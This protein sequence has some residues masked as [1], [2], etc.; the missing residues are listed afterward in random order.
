MLLNVSQD[1]VVNY[2][3]CRVCGHVWT[4]TKDDAIILKHVTTLA[5]A[6]HARAQ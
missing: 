6:A 4:T 2:H 5:K 3:R 1:A